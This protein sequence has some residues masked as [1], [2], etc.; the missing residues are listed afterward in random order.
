MAGLA[1]ATTLLPASLSATRAILA[2]DLNL[3]IGVRVAFGFGLSVIIRASCRLGCRKAPS[4]T[5]IARQL[6][7]GVSI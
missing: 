2:L 7:D 6:W 3:S 1:G 4:L 5:S